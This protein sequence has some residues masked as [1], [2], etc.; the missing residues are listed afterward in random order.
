M[1][2][3]KDS[4]SS[5]K[6]KKSPLTIR[7]KS[8]S[9]L[10]HNPSRSKFHFKYS[11]RKA[12]STFDL[13]TRRNRTSKELIE[14]KQENP[15]TLEAQQQ[16]QQQEQQTP[17][18]TPPLTDTNSKNKKEKNNENN[19]N[20]KIDSINISSSNNSV[21]PSDQYVWAILE[22]QIDDTQTYYLREADNESSM[23]SI[24]PQRYIPKRSGYQIGSHESCDIK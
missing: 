11:K 22:N 17:P 23:N 6:G 3:S 1:A 8:N 5:S 12:L 7:E 15:N 20:N 14:W 13:E 10:K 2:K 21:L 4:S 16:Q 9:T 24:D 18:L 19:N